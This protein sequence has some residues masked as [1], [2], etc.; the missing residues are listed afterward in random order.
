MLA[1]LALVGILSAQSTPKGQPIGQKGIPPD[2]FLL[3]SYQLSKELVPFDREILLNYLSLTGARHR[4]AFTSAWAEENLLLARQLPMIWN[5]WAV[6]KNSLVAMSY[7]KPDRAL[8][9]I[10]SMDLPSEG[11]GFREDI[12]SDGAN[13]IF[14]NY[15][16]AHQTKGVARLRDEATYLGHTGQYPY[17]AIEHIVVNLADTAPKGQGAI[18]STAQS[19]VTDA[20]F[21]YRRGSEF[22]VEDDDFVEFL[23]TL[24]PILPASLFKQGL[25]LAVERLLDKDRPHAKQG[26]LVHIQTEN[27]NAVFRRRQ[28]TL[29]FHL[30]PLVREVDPEWAEQIIQRD[31]T[32]GQAEGNNGKQIMS[33]GITTPGDWASPSDLADGLQRTR[34]D[35]VGQLAQ[36]DPAAARRL[37]QTIVDPSVRAI[38]LANLAAAVGPSAPR[39]AKEIENNISDSLPG[40]KDPSDR[41]KVLSALVKAAAAADDQAS[42]QAV[43]DRCF[44]LGEELFE[45]DSITDPTNGTYD[46]PA[47]NA[48]SDAVE[49]AAPIAPAMVAGK[50]HELRS[51]PL[52]AYLLYSLADALYAAPTKGEPIHQ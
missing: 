17:R 16:R 9:L 20:Y 11:L 36:S 31:Q 38:A 25:D 15:W 21:F 19:L 12:R 29:L 44:A 33:E 24:H 40:I 46:T 34:A 30:L 6:E 8:A 4:L 37:A 49:S 27:G 3:E 1:A 2:S 52:K 35:A 13:T 41:L 10:R 45:E 43:L 32:L 18:S 14:D 28:D 47:Y 42:L 48:L 51:T 5:R 22:E 7:V 26:Y 50:V 23:Q 39:E